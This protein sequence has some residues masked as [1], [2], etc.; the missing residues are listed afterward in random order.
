[1]L[2]VLRKQNDEE[3]FTLIEL[4]VVV[5]IIGILLAIAVPTFL[6]A[7]NNAKTKA[8]TS[9][10]RTSL[11]SMK[12]V[13]TDVQSYDSASITT[14]V[15]KAAEP[16]LG[17]QTGASTAPDQI[18]YAFGSATAPGDTV[19]LAVLSK[20]GDC[21]YIKDSV[22][23]TTGGTTF[24]RVNAAAAGSCTGTNA[25]TGATSASPSAANW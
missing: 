17:W 10:V 18:S 21:F 9:N 12:T 23:P 16:S 8:A 20:L 13:Y 1:M 15:L 25:L 6:K 4:M 2:D 11:S 3:G 7:Q 5:L 22:N 19:G 14:S 24:G